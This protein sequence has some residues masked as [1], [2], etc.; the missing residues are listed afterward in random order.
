MKTKQHNNHISFVLK[1]GHSRLAAW[2]V[3]AAKR[4]SLYE[5]IELPN[6]ISETLIGY[7]PTAV[8]TRIEVGQFISD[9]IDLE[10]VCLTKKE[11][12]PVIILN[13]ARIGN[14]RKKDIEAYLRSA[15][16]FPLIYWESST[17]PEPVI[18]F[19]EPSTGLRA[20]PADIQSGILDQIYQS[21][22]LMAA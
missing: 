3:P 20:C 18:R 2:T 10:A 16:A 6:R 19:Y 22:D 7:E 17:A 15:L 13:S 8:V 1:D 5:S 9:Q 4:P 21:A 11:D 14:H 12:R